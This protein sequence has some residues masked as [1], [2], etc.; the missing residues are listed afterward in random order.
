[1]GKAKRQQQQRNPQVRVVP[2]E[3]R[4]VIPFPAPDVWDGTIILGTKFDTYTPNYFTDIFMGTIPDDE[5]RLVG[6]L[7]YHISHHDAK[8]FDDDDE[9]V[10]RL[11][12]GV[13]MELNQSRQILNNLLAANILVKVPR[14]GR[15]PKDAVPGGSGNQITFGNPRYWT[16]SPFFKRYNSF[17]LRN[18]LLLAPDGM[19]PPPENAQAFALLLSTI[20]RLTPAKDRGKPVALP[21]DWL[22]LYHQ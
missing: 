20:D 1:M 7:Y 22:S 12:Y 19:V 8:P 16:L 3:Q 13:A 9:T 6:Y 11:G 17:M 21:P 18:Y 10:G 2:F 15:P 5:W 4:P 14:R